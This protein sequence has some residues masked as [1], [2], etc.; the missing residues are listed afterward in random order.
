MKLKAKYFFTC[1]VL[2]MGS[3]QAASANDKV[4]A[5]ELLY[6]EQETGTDVYSVRFI[7]TERY[8]RIDDLS[9][10]SGYILYDDKK[11]TIY[12]IS[13][14]DNS[15]LVIPAYEYEKPDMKDKIEE[16]YQPFTDA[17]KVSGKTVYHYRVNAK[18]S[19]DDVCMDMQLVP[20][21]LPDVVE[22]L[23]AYQKV[24]TGQQ[25]RGLK[26]IP[27]EY[28]T[29]CFLYDQIFNDGQY[30][31]KGLPIQEWHSN[32]KKKILASYKRLEVNSKLFN[33]SE[34]YREYSLD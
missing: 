1:L 33:R 21:L 3:T 2:A 8:L 20:G 9:D 24:V 13:H 19:S 7:I 23:R 14:F 34:N 22:I 5:Y 16:M 17:P 12:S 31:K 30:Y 11:S 28:Q 29:T 10:D 6:D 18:S 15:T 25:A 27:E 4:S 32:G 26:N